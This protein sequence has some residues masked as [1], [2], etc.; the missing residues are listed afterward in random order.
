MMV[1]KVCMFSLAA[2]VLFCAASPGS[3]TIIL[4]DF[5]GGSDDGW[6]NTGGGIMTS[7]NF[8]SAIHATSGSYAMNVFKDP[9]G[10]FAW[11]MQ[12]DH[13]DIPNFPARFLSNGSKVYA[14]V[15]WKTSEWTHGPVGDWARWDNSSINSGGG[16]MQTNDSLMTDSDPI[17]VAGEWNTTD[18]GATNVRT[19]SWDFSSLTAGNEAAII[20]GGWLQLNLGVNFDS[21]FNSSPG[22]SFWIDNIRMIPEPATLALF[23]LGGMFG[24][25]RRRR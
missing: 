14:D 7:T 4:G 25:V 11:Q 3:A 8:D 5:E 2:A 20:G 9:G 18:Y 22:Y 12:L 6:A 15:S 10:G 23:G 1:R 17:A 21:A 16:W 24:L 13:D 19:L